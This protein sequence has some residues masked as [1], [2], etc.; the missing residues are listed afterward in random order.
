MSGE[1]VNPEEWRAVSNS[2][3]GVP[4]EL[5]R[6][7]CR[8]LKPDGNQCKLREMTT[9]GGLCRW[10][11]GGVVIAREQAQRRLEMVRSA[12]FDELHEAALEAVET[13][14][15]IMKHGEKDA[16]RLRAADRVLTLVG[17]DD[18][19]VEP[20]KEATDEDDIDT[21][22]RALLRTAAPERLQRAIEVTSR[23]EET[24][25]AAR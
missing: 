8:A 16:D 23:E 21:Q 11:G 1:V 14:I 17:L 9:G 12:M 2:A 6:N 15:H 19:L 20:P 13:Y 25:D 10:H 24:S 7:Q 18:R 3:A 5:T 22:L 4:P